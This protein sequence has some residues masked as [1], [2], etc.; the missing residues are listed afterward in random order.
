MINPAKANE[1]DGLVLRDRHAVAVCVLMANSVVILGL[2]MMASEGPRS[3][4][5]VVL[6]PDN[7]DL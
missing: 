1:R 7:L 4:L 6:V 3:P 2:H 5:T